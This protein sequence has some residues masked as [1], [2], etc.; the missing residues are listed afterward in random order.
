MCAQNGATYESLFLHALRHY[1]LVTLGLYRLRDV[2]EE[3]ARR[4]TN[5]YYRF[6]M[7]NPVPATPLHRT[8]I[9]YALEPPS[10][11]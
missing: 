3:G 5:A 9:V 7:G 8:D 6:V 4:P 10:D 11:T 1:G 2:E